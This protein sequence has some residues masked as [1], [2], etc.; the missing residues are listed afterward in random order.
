MNGASIPAAAALTPAQVTSRSRSNFLRSFRA[1]DRERR[2]ALTAIYAFCRVVDDAGDDPRGEPKRQVEFWQQE[3]DAAFAG[4]PATEI[5]R[6]LQQAV[7]RYGVAREDLQ[8][9][10]EGV[11]QD[12]AGIRFTTQHELDDYCRKVAVAV[13]WACLP[14]F[15]ASAAARPFAEQLGL[16]L[17][18]TNILRDLKEDA[19]RG[20]VYVPEEA[21]RRFGVEREWLRGDGPPGRRRRDGPVAALT[22]H[23]VALAR[24]RFAQAE[25]LLPAAERR[26]LAAARIMAAVY[27][28]LLARIAARGGDLNAPRARVPN[29][30]KLWLY[31]K[32]RLLRW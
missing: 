28:D 27:R 26:Q 9:V 30:K 11:R 1:L 4:H 10:V 17:Q 20:R 22:A 31:W 19:V 24:E 29:W 8:Q 2:A 5:G 14:V 12:V 6:A 18:L 3:L 21:L 15:G 25:E 7:R 32:T 13:G 23:L 16:A